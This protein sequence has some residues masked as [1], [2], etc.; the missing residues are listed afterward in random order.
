MPASGPSARCCGRAPGRGPAA[1][2]RVTLADTDLTRHLPR[3]QEALSGE[4]RMVDVATPVSFGGFT[5]AAVDQFA[6]QL[7]ALGLEPR[8][9]V[10]A[11]GRVTAG[12]GPPSALKPGSMI[13]VQL[14][15]G[16]M[17]IAADGTV[18]H[19]DGSRIYAFGHRFLSVGDTALPFARAEVVTLLPVLS[20]SFK[21]STPREMMGTISEDRN[22]A[23]L[24][25]MGRAAPMAPLS[26][27]VSRGGAQQDS[28]TMQMVPDRFLSPLLVQMAVY[29]AIDATERT[30]GASSFRLTG[31]VEF[32]GGAAP[33]KLDNIYAADNGS[34]MMVSL[35]TAIPIA[36]VLQSG[37]QGVQMKRV[38]LEIESFPEKKQLQI[39]QVSVARP[40]VRPG[41]KVQLT[42]VLAGE[43]GVEVAR[44]VEYEVPIG[45]T[46]G[47]LCFTVAD[48]NTT[49]LAEFR[50]FIANPPRSVAQLMGLVN[51][52]RPN[53]KAYVR[54]WRP[55]PVVSARR[56]GSA[57]PAAL[58]RH[59]SGGHAGLHRRHQPDAQFETRGASDRRGRYD[60]H[61]L[62]D[63][64]SGS[65]GMKSGHTALR[66]CGAVV[67]CALGA[68]ASGTAAW[69]MNTWSDFIRGRFQGVSLSRDGR[70]TLAPRL[71]TVWSSDQPVVW[72]VVR[73][74]DGTLYAGTGHRG[75]VY[76]IDAAGKSAVLWTAEQ[77]EVFALALD[78]KGALYAAGSP[79]GKVYRIENGKAAE[80][81]APQARYVWSLA[82]APDGAL[83]VGT[84]DQGRIYRVTGAG[85]GR[86]VVRHRPV[87]RDE[88]RAGQPGPAA[89]GHR[90]E[91]NPLPD[92]GQG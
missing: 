26:V 7:R 63:R 79:D 35:S 30:V 90:A 66:L 82:M 83:F 13:S 4:A 9:A 84:G 69:E 89:G 41:E 8:Q 48:G 19:I 61:R 75:R 77:P 40:Y 3:P 88:P 67:A 16:D 71:E 25:E 32:E 85:A 5:R 80:Y 42:A 73:A 47:P 38:A 46:P 22:T 50:Q 15:T 36:Y 43:N 56:R 2:S 20:T 31:V 12:M 54:V 21:I 1:R 37:F 49:N 39:D 65:E 87:P 34:A 60:G 52:L 11:G 78:R 62:E 53:N 24:G 64:P 23:I 58:G 29:S 55:D 91:R 72:S 10:S 86:A 57:Q 68:Q 28:Y 74:P 17:S 76:R 33:L 59:D 27:K 18:T 45:A 6:P 44:K 92:H 81:F 14:M 51:N 70:L